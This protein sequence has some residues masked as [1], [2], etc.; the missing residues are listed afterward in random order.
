MAK[1]ADKWEPIEIPFQEYDHLIKEVIIGKLE[2][3]G[4]GVFIIPCLGQN[5]LYW[6]TM[7]KALMRTWVCT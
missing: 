6:L 5:D 4:F 1:G 3:Y 7:K 2:N